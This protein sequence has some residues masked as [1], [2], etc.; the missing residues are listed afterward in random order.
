MKTRRII[1]VLYLAAVAVALTLIPVG[2]VR[3]QSCAPPEFQ[4]QTASGNA[5]KCG[6]QS[7]IPDTNGIYHYY[8]QKEET[9]TAS[10]ASSDPYNPYS[11]TLNSDTVRTTSVPA[12]VESVILT[13]GTLNA[14]SVNCGSITNIDTGYP[15]WIYDGIP[16]CMWYVVTE[17]DA[18]APDEY[19]VT[20]ACAY[21]SPPYDLLSVFFGG[22]GYINPPTTNA[23]MTVNSTD[24]EYFYDD[25]DGTRTASDV[26]VQTLSSEFTDAML[27]AMISQQ[28]VMPSYSTNW[29]TG[30]SAGSANY[31]LDS[32]H[33]NGSGTSLEYC[34]AIPGSIKNATYH[35]QWSE[36]TTDANGNLVSTVP[37]HGSVVGTG[38]PVNPALG[39]IKIV[40]VPPQ[41]GSISEVQLIVVKV[42]PPPPASPPPPPGSG[43]PV[44]AGA[45]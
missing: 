44:Q 10:A 17:C 13:N 26:L 28:I 37:Q 41:P 5:S 30:D 21:S 38:D 11:G 40:A 42:D 31:S 25:G 18:G 12:C 14:I 39:D 22:D 33:Y 23:T 4:F 1:H 19:W 29:P 9:E 6:Y 16:R 32:G 20:N 34:L 35:C 7:W 27:A 24:Y 45:N 2:P 3:A 15:V 36:V 43:G 8:L